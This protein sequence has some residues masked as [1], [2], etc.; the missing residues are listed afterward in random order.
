MNMILKRITR[1]VYA[2]PVIIAKK[3]FREWK[4]FII[5][6]WDVIIIIR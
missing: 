1:I 3:R 5:N 6:A 4:H 2:E